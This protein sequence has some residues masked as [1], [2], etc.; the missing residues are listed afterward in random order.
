[1]GIVA[2]PWRFEAEKATL[3]G[4]STIG[5]EYKDASNGRYVTGFGN[6][7][8]A[9]AAFKVAIAS[10][11]GSDVI[12]TYGDGTVAIDFPKLEKWSTWGQS[13]I[14]VRTKKGMNTLTFKSDPGDGCIHFDYILV[15]K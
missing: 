14:A 3:S 1:M 9:S 11:G 4:G 13:R 10:D 8:G 5:K 15:D 6:T 7:T 2:K 12:V